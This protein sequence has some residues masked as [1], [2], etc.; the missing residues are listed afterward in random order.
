MM[1]KI[2]EWCDRPRDGKSAHLKARLVFDAVKRFKPARV[3]CYCDEGFPWVHVWFDEIVKPSSVVPLGNAIREA[4]KR[5][6]KDV[7]LQSLRPNSIYYLID[8]RSFA[9]PHDADLP[10]DHYGVVLEDLPAGWGR[11]H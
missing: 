7:L 8:D 9:T 1:E 10:A 4:L 3:E 2:D 6:E 5:H 11:Q